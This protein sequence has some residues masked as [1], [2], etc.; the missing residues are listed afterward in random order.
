MVGADREADCRPRQRASLR[1]TDAKPAT[2]GWLSFADA[3]SS[4]VQSGRAAARAGGDPLVRHHLPRRLRPLPL[5]L[6]GRRL[7][8]PQFA[9]AAGRAATSRTC[10]S[11]R[12]RRGGGR[13][14]RL[15]ALL[16][17]RHY[18]EHPLEVFAVW[19]AAWRSTAG[20]SAW[21]ARWRLRPELPRAGPFLQLMDLDRA[22]LPTGPAE[23]ARM[24]TSSTASW[25][26]V[27]ADPGL[28]LGDGVPAVAACCRATPRRSTSS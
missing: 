1:P 13:A 14:A 15:R 7:Q 16:Q 27:R 26:W 20:C 4:A 24:A 6:A 5:W 12:A 25:G 3:R 11:G 19:K 17:A 10:S 8:M 2:P 23:R 22:G 21:S 28:V 18:A 9:Q